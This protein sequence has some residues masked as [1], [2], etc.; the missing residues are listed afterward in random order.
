MI[1]FQVI[2]AYIFSGAIR[3]PA[4]SGEQPGDI[5]AT[6]FRAPFIRRRRTEPRSRH[7]IYT[8]ETIEVLDHDFPTLAE[9]VAAPHTR[10]PG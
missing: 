10:L 9:G 4:H 5:H 1:G 6:L 3:L 8:T 7:K 2:F